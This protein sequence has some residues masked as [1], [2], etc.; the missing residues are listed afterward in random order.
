LYGQ[1]R[2]MALWT[3]LATDAGIHLMEDCAQAHL[4]RWQG[5]AAGSFGIAGAYSFYPT[6]N[7]GAVG[8]GG[9]FVCSVDAL[10][11]RVGQLRNYG[12][13]ERYVHPELGMNSRLDELQAALLSARLQW[14]E[15]F[16]ARR[17]EVADAY[18]DGIRHSRVRLLLP[19]QE[20]AAHVHHLF[21]VL[22]DARAALQ[23]HLASRGVQTLIH[24][25]VPIHHQAPCAAL[26]RDPQ[27]LPHAEEHAAN[28]LSIPCHPQMDDVM[29]NRVLEAINDWR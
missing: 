10:A 16:T 20:D 1:V 23:D 2:D 6:K 28:C 4:A 5:R 19:A 18:N 24:Y 15:A 26:R 7:L 29:V 12:Q 22:S 3:A 14:L 13:S 9:A 25:P 21:V 8:D 17:R 27:G 11:R